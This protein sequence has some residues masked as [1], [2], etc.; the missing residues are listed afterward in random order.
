MAENVT[1]KKRLLPDIS[2]EEAASTA[3]PVRGPLRMMLI[4][5]G[6]NLPAGVGTASDDLSTVCR[7]LG[8]VG[9]FPTPV[10]MS[11]RAL[12]HVPCRA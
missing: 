5:Q 7:L 9:P 12:R 1:T 4:F 2:R 11:W 6:A 3:R 10:W 8:V